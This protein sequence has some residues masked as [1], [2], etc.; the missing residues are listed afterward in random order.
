MEY[1]RRKGTEAPVAE[2][3]SK[4]E[5]TFGLPPADRTSAP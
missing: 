1:L 4:V 2:I 5:E 3:R